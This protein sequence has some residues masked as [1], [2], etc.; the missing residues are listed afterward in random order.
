MLTIRNPFLPVN[1]SKRKTNIENLFDSMFN[2]ENLF[3]NSFVGMEYKKN[4]D[5]TL[6]ITA[7]LPGIKEEDVNIELS[8]DNVVSIRGERKTATSSYSVHKS[9]VLP[10]N[11]DTDNLK[12]ELKDGI[13]TLVAVNKP[14]P[15]AR[16][17]KKIPIKTNDK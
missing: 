14:L 12:A 6:S 7:D 16:E 11:Y 2:F 15:A 9:F 10:D 3:D 4:E 1:N 8:E 5:G 17:P 13:L